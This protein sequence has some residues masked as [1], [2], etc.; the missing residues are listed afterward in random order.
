MSEFIAIGMLND[1]MLRGIKKDD[2]SVVDI[3]N[4]QKY[5]AKFKK[6]LMKE[7]FCS[8]KLKNYDFSFIWNENGKRDLRVSELKM[9]LW[10]DWIRERNFLSGVVL[11]GLIRELISIDEALLF[12]D[13]NWKRMHGFKSTRWS[14]RGKKKMDIKRNRLDWV[15]KQKLG[16]L[17]LMMLNENYD[18]VE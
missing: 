15:Y 5:E 8:F 13:N 9:K 2:R 12:V 18:N 6:I 17:G 4:R 1:G 3:G 16:H 14:S 11:E 10:N 7:T